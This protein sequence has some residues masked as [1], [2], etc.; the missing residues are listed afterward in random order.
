LGV[1]LRFGPLRGAIRSSRIPL[2]IG[3]RSRFSAVMAL[4]SISGQFKN[5]GS[6]ARTNTDGFLLPA[7][8]LRKPAARAAAKQIW[9]GGSHPD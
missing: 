6:G 9:K 1:W 5:N 8:R 2:K 4:Y 3:A 7:C